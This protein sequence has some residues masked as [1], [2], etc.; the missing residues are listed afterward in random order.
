MFLDGNNELLANQAGNTPSDDR[1]S[2]IIAMGLVNEI[3]VRYSKRP[4][5]EKIDPAASARIAAVP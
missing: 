4:R 1:E 3:A 5:I 2:S